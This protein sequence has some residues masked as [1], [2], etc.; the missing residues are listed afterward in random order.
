MNKFLPAVFVG[1]GAADCLYG[2]IYRD[3]VSV[4]AGGLIAVI[5]VYIALKRKKR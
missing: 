1:L 5:A 2:I 4:V 3:P